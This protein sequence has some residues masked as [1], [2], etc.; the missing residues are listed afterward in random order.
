MHIEIKNQKLLLL[1][2][3]NWIEHAENCELAIRSGNPDAQWWEHKKKEC[4]E[5][6]AECIESL[7]RKYIDIEDLLKAVEHE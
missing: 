6:Y 5:K 2:A 3:L 7:L 4:A 1:A